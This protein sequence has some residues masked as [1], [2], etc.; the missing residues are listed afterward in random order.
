MS[1]FPGTACGRT[2]GTGTIELNRRPVLR[3][4]KGETRFPSLTNPVRIR[5]RDVAMVMVVE[6]LS[7][8]VSCLCRYE[9]EL[10][11]LVVLHTVCAATSVY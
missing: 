1:A 4:L 8:S 5:K 2:V 11:V 3:Q 10:H 9:C 6:P 7:A